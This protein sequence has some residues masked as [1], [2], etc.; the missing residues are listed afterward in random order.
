MDNLLEKKAGQLLL[1]R[2]LTIAC[3]ESCTGGLLTSRLTDIAGSSAYVQGSVVS[4]SN[5]IKNSHL[6][7][8]LETLEVHGAVSQE[9]ASEMSQGVRKNLQADIGVGIT[10]I[11]G[12]DGGTEKKPVGLVY[13][14]VAGP[15]GTVTLQNIFSGTRQEIKSQA[16]DKALNMVIDYL[17]GLG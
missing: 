12:P 13:I 17:E 10:G 6:N 8:S 2:R 1:E 7:V 5:A 3:G 14:S 11:A 9:T 16:T 4:Y 15:K